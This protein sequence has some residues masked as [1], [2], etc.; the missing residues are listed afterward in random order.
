M[1][2]RVN[3]FLVAFLIGIVSAMPNGARAATDVVVRQ[4]LPPRAQTCPSLD[5]SDVRPHV[6]GGALHSFDILISDSLYVA[7]GGSV[8]DARLSF[9]YMTRWRQVDGSLRIHV[10][11]ETTSLHAAVPV[12][13]TLLSTST[14]GRPI[15]CIAV[16]SALVAPAAE[17]E[18]RSNAPYGAPVS[19]ANKKAVPASLSV[20]KANG[21]A[22]NILVGTV[23]SSAVRVVTA[24]QA[25]GDVCATPT[26]SARL[27]VVLIV[28]YAIFAAAFVSQKDGVS[29]TRLKRDRHVVLILAIFV[30][31]LFFWYLSA[32]CR[33]GPWAPALATLV[34]CGG[35]LVVFSRASGKKGR[36]I[37]LLR[38][39]RERTTSPGSGLRKEGAL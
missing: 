34:A 27:G 9:Q 20:S 8:G 4:V 25:L 17:K 2:S 37:L 18:G 6:Y 23:G 14:G 11:V 39:S 1:R 24:A 35:L 29:D 36:D 32:P 26:G 3:F 5:A 16:I 28:L 33:V 38:S 13:I 31:L 10:D 12:R 7:V 21:S 30:A 22:T 15:T 19:A